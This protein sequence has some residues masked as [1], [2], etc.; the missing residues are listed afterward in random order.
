MEV[1]SQNNST[2]VLEQTACVAN[3]DRG[4]NVPSKR[5]SFEARQ[6]SYQS[7]KGKRSPKVTS[8]KFP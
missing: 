8:E 5:D 6:I 7:E 1:V 3:R 4:A 2:G